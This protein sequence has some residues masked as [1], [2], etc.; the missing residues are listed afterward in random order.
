MPEFMISI[1][2]EAL[3]EG[4][5][6]ATSEDLQGLVA[7][8]RTIA[9][10]MEIGPPSL[11]AEAPQET[12]Q[13]RGQDSYCRFYMTKLPSLTSKEVIGK[14]RKAGFVFDRQAKGSHEIWLNPMTRRRTTVPNHLGAT[15]PREH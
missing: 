4:G 2:I 5:Y 6:V 13:T 9:E 10:T 14:L 8:G 12:D 1:N 11:R 15:T 3:E 7:Q